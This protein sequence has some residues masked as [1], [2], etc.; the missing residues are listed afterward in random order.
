MKRTTALSV[1]AFCLF[2]AA[3]VPRAV[4]DQDSDTTTTTT[5]TNATGT[6][7]QLN[8]GADGEAR[9]FLI[10]ANVLLTFPSNIC[11]GVSTLGAV[12]NSVTYSGTASTATSGFETVR[13]SSFTNANTKTSYTA[14]TATSTAYGPPPARSSSS[15]TLPEAQ[16]TLSV[17]GGRQHSFC[18]H[19]L[20][21]EHDS[22][23]LAHRGRDGLRHWNDFVEHERVLLDRG[24]RVC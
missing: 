1:A 16:S 2:W 14:P 12:G 15:T 4:A 5:V 19:R 24:S 13:V 7:T 11:G 18:F 3:A 21:L 20:Y 10:G 8:Y 9:G 23:L 17:H 22:D 6:I